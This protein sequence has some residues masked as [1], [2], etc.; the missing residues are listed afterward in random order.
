MNRPMT[1]I[2][3]LYNPTDEHI[4]QLVFHER[5]VFNH[6]IIVDNS[7]YA[8]IGDMKVFVNSKTVTYLPQYH[9]TGICHAYNVGIKEAIKRGEDWVMLLDQDSKWMYNNLSKILEAIDNPF[10]NHSKTAVIAGNFEPEV[11]G[12]TMGLVEPDDNI[13]INSG[14]CLHLPVIEKI[15]GMMEELFIDASDYEFTY[16]MVTNGYKIYRENS[17]IFEHEL[18]KPAIVNGQKVKNYPPMRYFYLS[19]NNRIIIDMYKDKLAGAKEYSEHILEHFYHYAAIDDDYSAKEKL[20]AWE[21]G[22]DAYEKW[23]A[24]GNYFSYGYYTDFEKE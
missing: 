2:V 14:M 6:L 19:R 23:K 17:A 1:G 12:K 7:D 21:W 4:D 22:K 13:I 3:V 24:M 20:Q 11:H 16:R 8:S 15:G 5:Y 18:G 10:L 9:N